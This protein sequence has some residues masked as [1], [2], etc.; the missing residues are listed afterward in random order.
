MRSKQIFRNMAAIVLL[1]SCSTDYFNDIRDLNKPKPVPCEDKATLNSPIGSN[2]VNVFRPALNFSGFI[3]GRHSK[4]VIEVSK[5]NFALVWHTQEVTDGSSSVKIT[6]NLALN[7]SYQWR[8]RFETA[9]GTCPT[10]IVESFASRANY[11]DYGD[12]W[13]VPSDSST[14]SGTTYKKCNQGQTYNSGSCTGGVSAI[15]FCTSN[16]NSCNS[17]PTAPRTVTSGP[18]YTSCNTDSV[19]GGGWRVPTPNELDSV[20]SFIPTPYVTGLTAYYWTGE[21]D[22][23]TD[24]SGGGSHF[25]NVGATCDQRAQMARLDGW[26][27]FDDAKTASHYVICVRSF[28]GTEP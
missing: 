21:A 8:V 3:T 2:I 14:T 9:S 19:S 24:N 10:S 5:D 4:A 23:T 25:C 27:F 11:F 26:N 22:N 28:A 20:K 6:K 16:D 1:S 18:L 12:V 15:Q 7:T 13:I 17:S